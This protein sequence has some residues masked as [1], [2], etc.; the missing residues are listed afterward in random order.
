MAL[1]LPGKQVK[2][3]CAAILEGI[4]QY[5][6]AGNLYEKSESWDKAAYVYIKYKEHRDI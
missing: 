5:I 6:E 2:R 1:K 3:E 4:R